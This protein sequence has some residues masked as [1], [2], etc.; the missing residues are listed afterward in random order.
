MGL[1]L[2]R[3]Y[4]DTCLVIYFVENHTR[5]GPVVTT[6]LQQAT[7]VQF[8]ISPLVELE[9]LVVPLREN[10]PL[11]VQH[12]ER[13]F[14]QYLRL[15]IPRSVYRQAAELRARYNLKTPDALHLAIAQH[16][17]CSALWTNDDRLQRIVS[18]YAVNVC[19]GA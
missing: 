2:S 10:N 16:H 14:E 13:F 15:D 8:A 1:T 19:A 3:V 17:S 5:F 4:L 9:T 6:A 18:H 11:L 7:G 12:Y